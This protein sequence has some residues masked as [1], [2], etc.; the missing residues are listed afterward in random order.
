MAVCCTPLKRSDE[1]LASVDQ[2]LTLQPNYVEG[3]NNRGGI[4]KDLKRPDEALASYDRAL[5]LVPNYAE[6]HSNRGALLQ[7][8]RRLEEAEAAYDAAIRI[9]PSHVLAHVRKAQLLL[10]TGRTVEGWK[11]Y[12]WRFADEPADSKPV[13]RGEDIRG[14]RLLVRAEQGFGDM[15]QFCRYLPLVR[16]LGIEI[17]FEARA[18]LAPVMATL[19]C[20]MTIIANGAPLPDFDLSCRLLS[21][22]HIFQ[23]TL[24]SIPADIP[25]LFTDPGKVQQWEKKLGPKRNFRIGLVWSGSDMDLNRSIGLEELLALGD[26][27]VELHSLHKEY[28]PADV[29]LLNRTPAIHQ[30][31][32]AQQDFSDTAA[33]IAG[34]DL[35]I[36]VDTAVAHLAGAMG[37]PLWLLAPFVPDHRWLLDRQD[38]PWYRTAKLYRQDTSR[39]WRSVMDRV[40]ADLRLLLAK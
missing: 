40:M 17:V 27:P 8:L 28:R 29:A 20:P 31:Q 2:A 16:A 34:M 22:P 9:N 25:Y 11:H 24:D 6:A 26:L 23:T 36:S 15:I 35:I 13:W 32:D 12:E 19:N 21:L 37:K 38:S 1:A 10:L 4:L 18:R 3:H 39:S 5:E 7:F 33:L 30:H 14:K